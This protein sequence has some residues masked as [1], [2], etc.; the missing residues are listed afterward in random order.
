MPAPAVIDQYNA[1]AAR[2]PYEHVGYVDGMGRQ[3]NCDASN[4]TYSTCY[5]LRDS[6]GGCF[7]V[8]DNSVKQLANDNL[9]TSVL[10]GLLEFLGLL[11]GVVAL[12]L[13]P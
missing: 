3:L 13:M 8:G 4:L 6:Y 10:V 5:L 1:F 12:L 7:V 2:G 9:V 11:L